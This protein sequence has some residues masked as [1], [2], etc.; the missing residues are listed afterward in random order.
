MW[1]IPGN[2]IEYNDSFCGNHTVYTGIARRDTKVSFVLGV[3]SGKQKIYEHQRWTRSHASS[4][5][6]GGCTHKQGNQI[7]GCYIHVWTAKGKREDQRSTKDPYTNISIRLTLI[8]ESQELN[9]QL[10]YILEISLVL[11][12]KLLPWDYTYWKFFQLDQLHKI[13]ILMFGH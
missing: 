5:D 12:Q 3:I 4:K 9:K 8:W 6:V 10:F 7:R 11:Y 1:F 13:R 2:D